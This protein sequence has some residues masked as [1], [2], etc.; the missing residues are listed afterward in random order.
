[1]VGSSLGGFRRVDQPDLGNRIHAQAA[2]GSMYTDAALLPVRH[3][4]VVSRAGRSVS[5]I[6]CTDEDLL[7]EMSIVTYQRGWTL[8]AARVVR[9][10]AARFRTL[11]SGLRDF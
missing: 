10:L 5:V 7:I 2:D 9:D 3:Q 11:R 8:G 6:R 4:A 1:M